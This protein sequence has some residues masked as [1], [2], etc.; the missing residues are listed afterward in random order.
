MIKGIAKQIAQAKATGGGNF[1]NPGK[2]R[3][4]V[5]ALKDGGKPEFN[6]GNTFVAEMRVESCTGYQGMK[7]ETGKEKTAG[8]QIG[9]TVSYICQFEEFP[10][11]AFSNCKK[12]VLA[13]LGETEETLAAAA[14]ETAKRL[15]AEGKLP[16]EGW[17]ADDEFEQAYNSLV[18]RKVNP[19]R[20]MVI[21]YDTYE[22]E[23]KK[24]KK[25]ITLP[26]WSSVSQT[27]ADIA[28]K[29]AQLDGGTT[30]APTA[31]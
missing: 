12:L 30:P 17:T 2:G 21:D 16:A 1:T 7:D 22:K 8:N 31:G 4:V 23:T 6:S 25:I 13:L 11:T 18:D 10:E 28:A 29:R 9:S 26:K 24:T 14:A 3:L 15:Q 5:L 20:G 27:E 19:A